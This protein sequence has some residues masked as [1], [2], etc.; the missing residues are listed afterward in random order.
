MALTRAFTQHSRPLQREERKKKVVNVF[1]YYSLSFF[2]KT[3]EK[4]EEQSA[5]EGG[6]K[7]R[8]KV[9]DEREGKEKV[10]KKRK[11][12]Q[13]THEKNLDFFWPRAWGKNSERRI[14]R[15]KS[16]CAQK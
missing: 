1:F 15:Q 9:N 10:Y 2:Q 4:A 13:H 16:A 14:D 12:L 6:P 5:A 11:S 3:T 7:K 8:E